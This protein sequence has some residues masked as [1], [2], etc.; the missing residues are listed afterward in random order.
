MKK[1]MFITE[2]FNGVNEFLN[3]IGKREPNKVF[4]GEKLS[5]EHGSSEFTMTKDYAESVELMTTGYKDGLNDLKKCKGTA[6]HH[7]GNIRKLLERDGES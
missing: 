2:T 5:S 7:T 6:V 4:K 1:G 3:V